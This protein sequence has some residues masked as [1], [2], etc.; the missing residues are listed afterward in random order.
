MVEFLKAKQ[1]QF[2]NKPIGV[3]ATNTGA[4]EVGQA[5]TNAGNT[6]QEIAFRDA[7]EKQTE[8]GKDYAKGATLTARDENDNLTYVKLPDDLS[9]VARK[10][11][12]PVLEKRYMN[13]LQRDTSTKFSQLH[14]DY[15]D[16]PDTFKSKVKSYI[17]ETQ[18][19]LIESGYSDLSGVYKDQ[20]LT[21]SVQHANKIEND[22]YNEQENAANQLDLEVA[23][24][25]MQESF[26]I[27]KAGDIVASDAIDQVSKTILDDLRE[28]KVI[29]QPA[30]NEA[31]SVMKSNRLRALL[32]Q[33]INAMDGNPQALNALARSFKQNITSADK[34]ILNQYG[35]TQD[36]LNDLKS[37]AKAP[38]VDKVSSWLST[39]KGMYA[40]NSLADKAGIRIQNAGNTYVNGGATDTSAT[41]GNDLDAFFG[42][43]FN[44]GPKLLPKHI[45]NMPS[46]TLNDFMRTVVPNAVV[47]SSVKNLIN[48]PS[49]ML[50]A[51]N[52]AINQ[53]NPALAKKIIDNTLAVASVVHG[54]DKV[55][56]KEINRLNLLKNKLSY[57]QNPVEAMEKVYRSKETSIAMAE[58]RKAQ[59]FKLDSS[60]QQ[61]QNF[62]EA[63]WIKKRLKGAFDY[64]NTFQINRLTSQYKDLLESGAESLDEIEDV[65]KENVE[66]V[67]VEH[68]FN[69]NLFDNKTGSHARGSL[70][71]YY[72]N[73][74]TL[75]SVE[76][77][78][79]NI[80]NDMIGS[81]NKLGDN[82]FLM[83]D[84]NN[85][86]TGFGRWTVVNADK[87][88]Q[89]DDTGATI[90]ITT[91][92]IADHFKELNENKAQEELAKVTLDNKFDSW[93]QKLGFNILDVA[94][95][96]K[97]DQQEMVVDLESV[98][99]QSSIDI[100][101]PPT[102]LKPD[103]VVAVE[104][105]FTGAKET[106][107]D[108]VSE[109]MDKAYNNDRIIRET[110]NKNINSFVNKLATE[111]SEI[112][113]THPAFIEITSM[114]NKD[115]LDVI[116]DSI[117]VKRPID[118]HVFA[119]K[120]LIED[121]G[122]S[123]TQYPDGKGNSVGYG[124]FVNS[125][126]PDERA[127]IS[128]INNITKPEADAVLNVKVKKIHDKFMREVPGFETFSATRQA[129]F[130]SF[131][132]QL[133][134]E[135]VTAK[136]P[137]PNKNW[138]KF[139]NAMKRAAQE[140]WNS[141]SRQMV[142]N[143]V[144]KNMF[145]NFSSDGKSRSNTFWYNQTP[146]RAVKVGEMI[147]G[148]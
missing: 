54:K 72:K 69:I 4:T 79:Q 133:G 35:I 145:Y 25:Q 30:Y 29:K 6:I 128:D 7:I 14:R 37:G 76:V 89:R 117:I 44:V 13:M 9:N 67:F 137:D 126:E 110:I 57:T 98:P 40:S 12:K 82:V 62:T 138:P 21:L 74:D 109:T 124:F 113:R 87:E 73:E 116:M 71:G 108:F 88:P 84:I 5:L 100:V 61:D 41:F 120:T 135:N 111:G 53:N 16:D 56:E 18:N 68:P 48:N 39:T 95:L 144:R 45:I 99:S 52:N 121:E 97:K 81:D 59:I 19:V 147:R 125:L 78:S 118:S 107:T 27:A 50:T 122:F 3:I 115:T 63:S 58:D 49:V 103:S 131:A 119:V 51:V 141:D 60:A 91:D 32:G 75:E 92:Q 134:Y 22:I 36:Y 2:V 90:T 10:A 94:G 77:F 140:P 28:R 146:R 142:L 105:M 43:N 93:W 143:E 42:Q 127:M 112:L 33:K 102:L 70:A 34:A 26:E 15:K 20:A 23:S 1:T 65:I 80:V 47:P 136:G 130:I 55:S 123:A 148:Y 8:V 85:G 106:V 86:N 139:F 129:G 64:L 24:R 83:G 96:I 17:E 104:K 46:N 11:A 66:K 132:Y 114:L 31:M 101:E 38:V